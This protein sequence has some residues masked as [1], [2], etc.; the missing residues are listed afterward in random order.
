MAKDLKLEDSVYFLGWRENPFK[1]L[2]KAKIFVSSSLREGLPSSILEAMACGLPIVSLDCEFG[3]REILAPKTD[4]SKNAIGIEYGEFG[5]LVQVSN[6]EK[7][8]GD[9]VVEVLNDKMLAE[10]WSNKSLQRVSD[11][12]VS[13]IIKEWDFLGK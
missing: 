10:K 12:D 2:S 9:A 8:L 13:K 11:F 6:C 1:F 3:P 4:I 5:T 7:F